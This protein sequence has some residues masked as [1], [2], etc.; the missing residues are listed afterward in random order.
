[1]NIYESYSLS[2]DPILFLQGPLLR[3]VKW[4]E[5][6]QSPRVHRFELDDV[7]VPL[8]EALTCAD[9]YEITNHEITWYYMVTVYMVYI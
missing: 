1:M 6:S 3:L 8:S 2:Y 4:P 7:N 5:A 9:D